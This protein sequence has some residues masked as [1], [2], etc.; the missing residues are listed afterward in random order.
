[1]VSRRHWTVHNQYVSKVKSPRRWQCLVLYFSRSTHTRCPT[2]L[3]RER[4]LSTSC[5]KSVLTT[6]RRKIQILL[7]G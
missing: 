4:P 6:S 5:T 1:M 3:G 7:V 2:S